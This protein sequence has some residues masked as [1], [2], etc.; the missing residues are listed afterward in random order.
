MLLRGRPYHLV[1]VFI[2]V[3]PLT[4]VAVGAYLVELLAG[5]VVL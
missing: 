4:A 3:F 1:I 2:F 5:V